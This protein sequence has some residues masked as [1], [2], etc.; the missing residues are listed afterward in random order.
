MGTA[1]VSV[2]E[3]KDLTSLAIFSKTVLRMFIFFTCLPLFPGRPVGPLFPVVPGS[4]FG[5]FSPFERSKDEEKLD[6][7]Q[8]FNLLKSLITLTFCPSIPGKP[9][10]PCSETEWEL[11]VRTMTLS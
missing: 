2:C 3:V 9:I 5:P 8:I 4:P 11:V 10:E 6:K 7:N 1:S